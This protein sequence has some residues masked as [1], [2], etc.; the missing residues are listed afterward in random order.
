MTWIRIIY[1]EH[2]I[3]NAKVER[4]QGII[5][6]NR[7]LTTSALNPFFHLHRY[8]PVLKNDP[9]ANDFFFPPPVAV[10]QKQAHDGFREL[11][12]FHPP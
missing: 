3:T 4:S 6:W 10:N 11:R 5:C 12:A 2:H 8:S 1:V 9:R 7:I